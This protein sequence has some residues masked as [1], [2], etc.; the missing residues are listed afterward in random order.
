M[1]IDII[2]PTNN[3]QEINGFISSLDKMTEFKKY[4]ILK[5]IGNGKVYYDS[6]LGGHSV[7]YD[8]TRVDGDYKGRPVPFAALRYSAMYNSNC[9][10]FLFLDD[11]HRF[12]SSDSFLID[13][14]NILKKTNCSILCTDKNKKGHSGLKLKEDG[15][16]WTNKGLFIKNIMNKIDFGLHN[17]LLG[18][19]E[20]LLISYMVLEQE[21]LPYTLYGSNITRKERRHINEK[22]IQNISYSKEVMDYNIIGYLRR[23]FDD[24]DWNHDSYNF[25]VS[26]PKRLKTILETRIKNENISNSSN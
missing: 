16:I 3:P 4:C 10:Y 2:I 22:V 5:I 21:G 23:Y 19:G 20:D 8:V 1:R 24:R 12:N 17:L 14:L 26:Y 18:A 25:S 7:N 9:D 6:I 11:D 13:C 15:F